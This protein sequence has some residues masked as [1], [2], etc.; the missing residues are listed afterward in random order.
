VAETLAI[1]SLWRLRH[2]PVS[3]GVMDRMG[4]ERSS[5]TVVTPGSTLQSV[6]WRAVDAVG[7]PGWRHERTKYIHWNVRCDVRQQASA[8]LWT[9]VT[10]YV[11]FLMA[12]VMLE[13]TSSRAD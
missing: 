11:D 10:T 8:R 2:D 13:R 7:P 12:A 1:V 9:E 6:G 5:E 4:T 3:Y